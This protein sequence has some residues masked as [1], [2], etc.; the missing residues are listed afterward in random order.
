MWPG[1]LNVEGYCSVV[2]PSVNPA[3]NNSGIVSCNP[4]ARITNAIYGM[5]VYCETCFPLQW[6]WIAV[7]VKQANTFV[8]LGKS[9]LFAA[10]SP[11]F[12]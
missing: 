5:A 9:A 1:V 11:R 6:A 4:A 7:L 8:P 2:G 3:R 10:R 12:R